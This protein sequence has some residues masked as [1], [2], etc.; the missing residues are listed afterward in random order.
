[1][2]GRALE[3]RLERRMRRLILEADRL[4]VLEAFDVGEGDQNAVRVTV[5]PVKS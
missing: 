5:K 4:Q 1:V 2:E 3:L